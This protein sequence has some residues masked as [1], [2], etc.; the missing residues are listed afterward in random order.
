M[1]RSLFCLM[2][3]LMLLWDFMLLI[4]VLYFHMMIEKV[5]ASATAVL[6]WFALYKFIYHQ[7]FSPG[8]PG[9]GAFRSVQ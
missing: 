7:S 2:A 5:L 1:V 3:L 4:T 6:V 8:Q 9:E